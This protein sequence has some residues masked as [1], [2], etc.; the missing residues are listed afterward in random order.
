M[1]WKRKGMRSV[2]CERGMEEWH[3]APLLTCIAVLIAFFL[4]NSLPLH[5]VLLHAD[6]HH[7]SKP[8]ILFSFSLLSMRLSDRTQQPPCSP[9]PWPESSQEW[10][11]A[12]KNLSLPY[13]GWEV[14]HFSLLQDLSTIDAVGYS[15]SHPQRVFVRTCHLDGLSYASR[16][17]WLYHRAIW[18]KHLQ[19][20]CLWDSCLKQEIGH[21]AG[22]Q[23]DGCQVNHCCLWAWWLFLEG[24]VQLQAVF[25]KHCHWGN[26]ICG[27]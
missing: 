1:L 6:V 8:S 25:F 2:G 16:T 27:R 23:I 18:W 26:A 21:G 17:V 7:L 4:F 9:A 22:W 14:V 11:G 3:L 24:K 15:D 19:L 5:Q 20:E 12:T 13:R 10:S